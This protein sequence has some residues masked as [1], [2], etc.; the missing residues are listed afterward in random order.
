MAESVQI[1]DCTLRD[2]GYYNN[3]D[4]DLDLAKTYLHS[5]TRASVDA[6]EIGFRFLPKRVFL[7][8]FAYSSDNFLEKLCVPKGILIGVMINAKEYLEAP[9]EPQIIINQMFQPSKCSPVGLVRIAVDFDDLEKTQV[10]ISELKNLGY[11]V[12]LNLMQSQGKTRRQYEEA[13]TTIQEWNLVD[14]LYFAD[15]LGSMHPSEVSQ[16]CDALR[17]SWYGGLGIHTHDNKGLALIN[18]LSGIER[19][20]TWCDSTILGMGRGAGNVSTEALMLECV[21]QSIHAGD[22]QALSVCSDIFE[23]LRQQYNWG[24]NPYYHFAANHGIHPTFVQSLLNDP[25]YE[26]SRVYGI[27]DS[28]ARFSSRSFSEKVLREAA[29]H[30]EAGQKWGTWDASGWL[31]DRVVLLIGAGP[32]VSKYRDAIIEYIDSHNSAVLFLNINDHIPMA[33][34]TA[35]IAANRNRCLLDFD[36][37]RE[38]TH[39]LIMPKSILGSDF[40]TELEGLEILDYGINLDDGVFDIGPK[41]CVVQWPL[42][43][44]YAL[45]VITQAKAKEIL[46]VGFDGYPANDSRQEEMNEVIHSYSR[47]QVSVPLKS[48]TP[49]S[50]NIHQGSIFAPPVSTTDFVLVIP[51]RFESSRFPGKPLADLCGKS[52]IRHVWDKCVE[53][54]GED[55]V[56]VA[57]DDERIR[58]HCEEQGIKIVMTEEECMT[59][60]D[61]V[62]EVA[63]SVKREIYINVQ[64]DEPLIDPADIHIVLDSARRYPDAI[65]NGM[66]P[67]EE[68]EF[69]NPNVPKVVNAPDGRLLYMSRAPIPTGKKHE[70]IQAKR[71]VCIYAFPRQAILEFGRQVEKTEI[72]ALEDIEV[73]RFLELGYLVRM[74]DVTGS[75]VA[76]DTPED[77]KRAER[78]LKS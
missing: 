55:H 39:P 56:L 20:A 58:T 65:I 29:Y 52:V 64:G 33:L 4:F 47:L 46:L 50:Y 1:L 9:E 36:R 25:R 68:K 41:G 53:A 3:W 60:T 2:G 69:R 42:T 8:P 73:L 27:L 5:I 32:S 34:G 19:G 43:I 13:A 14:L 78:V 51:A 66:C 28:L 11:K 70:F 75:A 12:G 72:E 48:L 30:V 67:I 54:V 31:K 35:T 38:L 63:K 45:S 59:G 21:S 62:C 57:T 37:Y 26:R 76:I 16:I 18:S 74:V 15:S 77:L 7:G 24:P 49:T 44:A 10:L 23:R 17:T 71:Q 22:P 40:M 6:V 61:R